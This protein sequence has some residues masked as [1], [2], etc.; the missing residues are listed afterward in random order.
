[1]AL[2]GR[3]VGGAASGIGRRGTGRRPR[4]RRNSV[5][6]ARPPAVP[7]G[8]APLY[9]DLQPSNLLPHLGE[10]LLQIAAPGRGLERGDHLPET[11]QLEDA[12]AARS[13]PPRRRGAAPGGGDP[14]SDRACA[15][16]CVGPRS[17]RRR[18]G[19]AAARP[20]PSGT[21][22]AGGGARETGRRFRRAG[23]GTARDRS[24]QSLPCHADRRYR[25][26]A[27]NN[28]PAMIEPG[29]P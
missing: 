29:P 23:A 24:A 5:H 1:M 16:W 25:L 14:P 21:A 2:D 9:L 13:A 22:G 27:S 6:R 20:R 18:C 15:R 4:G 7:E 8:G 17:P 10:T 3:Q 26:V 12:G 28:R 19:D 11:G